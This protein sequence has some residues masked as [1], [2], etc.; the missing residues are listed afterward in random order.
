MEFTVMLSDLQKVL[1]KVLPAIPPKSTVPVLEHIYLKL[2]A[3]KLQLIATDQ[4][5]ILMSKLNVEST[6]SG[7]ILVPA[8]TL[9]DIV[10]A[11]GNTGS[12]RFVADFDNYEITLHSSKGIYEM[13]GLDADE[14][15]DM[16]QLFDYSM[17]ELTDNEGLASSTN[18]SATLT[19]EQVLYLCDKTLYSVSTDEYRVSM[20]GVLFQFRETFVN[21]VS[22]DS[23]R[24]SK[25]VVHS[26]TPSF[27]QNFE[28]LLP[29]RSV[30]ILK[31]VDADV[32]MTTIENF[33]KVSH[34]RFDIGDTTFITRII[35]E[36]FPPYENVIPTANE[37]NLT[38]D[39][40]E[41]L[42]SLRRVSLFA[43]EKSKQV[44]LL[45]DEN[46]LKFYAEDDDTGKSGEEIISCEFNAEHYE[47]IFNFKYLLEAVEH[48]TAR[49]T[50]ENLLHISFA[51]PSRPVL[52]VP[53]NDKNELLLLVM[54][55]RNPS[56]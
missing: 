7:E 22:T 45:I 50:T 55:I 39:I 32:F 13:K 21:A 49:D 53:N 17:P 11:L 9:N 48:I 6:D 52:I 47:I 23:F 34:I 27:P 10:K 29:A 16:P 46:Q 54:P 31:K 5:I 40:D 26:D 3:D 42:S 8:R 35:N 24:L 43:N 14:Y 38:V 15:I 19:K 51:E 30:E 2:N 33:G 1:Q 28:V 20:T 37:K 36:K 25:A 4:N 18:N 56:Y 44:K 12:I 41:F